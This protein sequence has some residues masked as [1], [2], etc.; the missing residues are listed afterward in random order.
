MKE[1]ILIL[2]IFFSLALM[3]YLGSIA[4]KNIYL[5]KRIVAVESKISLL[6]VICMWIYYSFATGIWISRDDYLFKFLILIFAYNIFVFLVGL[7][8]DRKI[9]KL[10]YISI[11]RSGG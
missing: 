4:E 5:I 9:V 8:N 7:I 3:M 10:G 1:V 11:P 6:L 2:S